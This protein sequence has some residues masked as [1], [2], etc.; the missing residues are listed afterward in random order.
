MFSYSYSK[1]KILKKLVIWSNPT[2]NSNFLVKMIGILPYR[3]KK[4]HV[5]EYGQ[6]FNI[7]AICL[8]SVSWDN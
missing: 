7:F 6:A 4:G 5:R 1:D 3:A 2:S 8:G